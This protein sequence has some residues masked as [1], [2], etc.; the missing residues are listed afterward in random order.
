MR[1]FLWEVFQ[2]WSRWNS[3]VG[4]G[5]W[6]TTDSP[7]PALTTSGFVT[8]LTAALSNRLTEIGPDGQLVPELAESW[9]GGESG[10][11]WHFKLRSGVEFHNGKML[12]ANDVVATISSQIGEDSTSAAKAIANQRGAG[13]SDAPAYSAARARSTRSRQRSRYASTCSGRGGSNAPD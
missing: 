8:V 12:D 3:S 11:I 9:E 5:P 2:P 7:N 13:R 10:K 6:G 4:H 1:L